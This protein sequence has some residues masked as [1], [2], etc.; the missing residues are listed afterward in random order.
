MKKLIPSGKSLQSFMSD[1]QAPLNDVYCF[2][3]RY[4]WKK[5]KAFRNKFSLC[6]PSGVNPYEYLWP[7]QGCDIL[8]FDTSGV[9]IMEIEN[10]ASCLLSAKA[11]IVRVVL[12]CNQ[13]AIYRGIP[14]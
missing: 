9:H 8:A 14:A 1:G 11:S 2:I 10:L 6:L 12:F 13:L 5:A 7:V 3:G 4:A